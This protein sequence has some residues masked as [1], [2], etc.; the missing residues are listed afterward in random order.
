MNSRIRIYLCARYGRKDELI[1]YAKRLATNGHVITSSWLA[2]DLEDD[3][4]DVKEKAR[5]AEQNRQDLL[6]SDVIMCF[7]EAPD[8]EFARGGRH[9]E[10]GIALGNGIQ[11]I[12]VEHR[13]NVFAC[14]PEI[15]FAPTFQDAA[16][17]VGQFRL[18]LKGVN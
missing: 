14:L 12:V 2:S 16:D 18:E 3:P 9:V 4:T 8:S 15:Y 10:L 1:G 6:N 5:I 13:E 17:F 11:P 7:A